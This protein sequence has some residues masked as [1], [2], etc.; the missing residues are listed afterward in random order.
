MEDALP[1][2]KDGTFRGFWFKAMHLAKLAYE[3]N[4]FGNVDTV[5]RKFQF[6]KR[7]AVERWG[8]NLPSG[9]KDHRDETKEFDF[10]HVI[11]PRKGV[12]LD[13]GAWWV[14]G[15]PQLCH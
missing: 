7:Q 11:R 3:E 6:T 5:Y 2:K 10:I 15:V 13:A 12:D 9:I 4:M 8:N 1:L 14:Y